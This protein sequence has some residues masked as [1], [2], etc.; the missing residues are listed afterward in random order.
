[1]AKNY[2]PEGWKRVRLGNVA[3]LNRANWDPSESTPIAYLDLTAVVSPGKLA[4]PKVIEAAEAPSRARRKV[5][6]GDILVSTVRPNLRGFAKVLDGPTNL[7]ASTG[8]G[9]V[10]PAATVSGS[11]V[12][13]HIMTEEFAHHLEQATTGQA[14]PAVRPADIASYQILLPPLL[15]Q[16][17]IAAVLDSV[18]EAMEHTDAVI[19]AT[20]QLRDSLLHELLTRGVPG[21][22]TEWKDVPGL[23]SIP[24]DWDVVRLGDVAEVERGKFAHRPRNEPRFYGGSTPFIQTGDVVQANGRIKEHS[25]TLNEL[26]LSISRLFPTGTIV[27]TIAANIGETAIT[28]YPVAFPDSLV[29][30]I[31]TAIDRRFL[32]YFLRTQKTR[33][34]Q[35]APE[36]AQKNINLEDLRPLSTPVPSQREQTAIAAALHRVEDL[37]EQARVERGTR[38]ALKVSASEALLTGRVRILEDRAVENG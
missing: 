27:I 33:L 14:Y 29:G 38:Q 35:F 22:H 8:F 28:D 31:P 37:I 13:Q 32:E 17:A 20:E 18:D 23:G 7:V 15:E 2:V 25:Q 1:M 34:S 19:A 3:E 21:W 16:R 11:F 36:S 5:C 24:A 26:G 12:Y 6:S 9:V 10:T 4:T 30:I